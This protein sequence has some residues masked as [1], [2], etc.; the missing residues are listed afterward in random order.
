MCCVRRRVTAKRLTQPVLGE[1]LVRAIDDA[2]GGPKDAHK[3]NV[4]ADYTGCALGRDPRE[5]R[6]GERGG[7]ESSISPDQT[8]DS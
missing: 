7:R 8:L 6:Y 2:C 5:K 1:P 4:K 3:S